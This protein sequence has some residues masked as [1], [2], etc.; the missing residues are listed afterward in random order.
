MG[1][2]EIGGPLFL[3]FF[4]RFLYSWL[5]LLLKSTLLNYKMITC[6]MF[7]LQKSENLEKY[8]EN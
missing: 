8:K 7:H 1:L 6:D 5:M 4:Q 2:R 3:L